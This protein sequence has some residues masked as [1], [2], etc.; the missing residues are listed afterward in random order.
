MKQYLIY[1]IVA[2]LFVAWVFGEY[3]MHTRS[4]AINVLLVAAIILI[5]VKLVSGAPTPYRSRRFR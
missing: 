5:S 3:V 1:I 2:I 4:N